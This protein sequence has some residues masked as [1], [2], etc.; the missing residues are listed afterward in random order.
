[1][2]NAIRPDAQAFDE[3]R[4]RVV[5]RFKDSELSGSEWRISAVMEFYR[6]GKLI[7]DDQVS[8]METACGVLYSKYVSAVDDG[9]GYFGGDGVH[10]DQEGCN[11]LASFKYAIKQD[12]CSGYGNC[13]QKKDLY[14]GALRHFCEKHSHRGDSDLQDND[15]N[16]QLIEVV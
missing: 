7:L 8:N 14:N 5:P 6:K 2:N 3:I 16:Y 9:H 10:C 1:M 15:E 11:E 12:Y 4:I 13:G